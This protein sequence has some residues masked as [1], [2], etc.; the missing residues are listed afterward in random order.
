MEDLIESFPAKSIEEIIASYVDNEVRYIF[1]MDDWDEPEFYEAT[2][3]WEGQKYK[4][5]IEEGS[6]IEASHD[7]RI[8]EWEINVTKI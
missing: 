7:G 6:C 4:V 8:M 3:E 5:E 2:T 1:G